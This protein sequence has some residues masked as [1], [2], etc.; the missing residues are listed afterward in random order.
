MDTSE[1]L[2]LIDKLNSYIDA[3]FVSLDNSIPTEIKVRYR[4]LCEIIDRCNEINIPIPDNVKAEHAELEANFSMPSKNKEELT[5]LADTLSD[6]SKK[7]RSRLRGQHNT[8]LTRSSPKKL[9]VTFPDGTTIFDIKA[10]DVFVQ[11]LQHIGLERIAELKSIRIKGHPLVSLQRNPNGGR[12]LRKI[13]NYF[14]ETHSSTEQ[15]AMFIR[16][17]AK[18]LNIDVKVEISE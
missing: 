17:I 14:I 10:A 13:D 11:A 18:E 15:K 3:K 8:F 7:I 5:Q 2:E 12:A 1:L 4:K 9:K 16:R 6:L